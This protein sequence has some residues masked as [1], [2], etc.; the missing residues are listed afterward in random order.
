MKKQS[1]TVT[2]LMGRDPEQASAGCGGALLT[3][4]YQLTMVDAY[5][6]LR[7]EDTAVFE[8]FVRRL[9]DKRNFLL[10]AGLEQALDYLETLRFTAAEIDWLRAMQRL[11][12]E[13]LERLRDFRFT[14]DVYAMAE[15]TAF[16]ASEPVLRVEAPLPEAQL[17]ES[18]I[19]NLLQY[20]TMVASKAARARLAAGD[21]PLVDFG[22]RRAHGAEAACF[23]ARAAY[24]GGVEST[25][26][27]EAARR[28]GIRAV[29]TMAHSFIQAHALELDAFR[30]FAAC[31][32]DNVVLLI[33]TYD[34]ARGARRAAQLAKRLRSD[35]VQVRGVRIDS[36]DL[37]AE[38]QRVRA[39]LDDEGCRD[40]QILVS[41]GVDEYKIAAMRAARAPV[42]IYCLGTR[43]TVSAD[44]PSLDCAYKLQQYARRPVRKKSVWKESWPGPRQVYRQLDAC[45]RIEVDVLACADEVFEGKALLQPVMLHGR[46]VAPSPSLQE[47]RAHC[48]AEMDALPITLRML[49]KTNFSPVKISRGQHA[50]T[51]EVDKS[52]H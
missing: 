5:Y 17:I 16:F 13:C 42:D 23:A 25:A 3:D 26:T 27:V 52:A 39:I 44:A 47:V 37:G 51:E 46:R 20:Q 28:Y 36:G 43:L 30:N 38:A 19:V 10:A 8:F 11:S 34:T 40:I 12:A 32:P 24:I 29:G 49:E 31:H 15:G 7:M 41:G 33:D 22:M 18:R 4:L 14:G 45:D 9:P 2:R 21:A 6:R 35:G 50:L 1:T 48:A